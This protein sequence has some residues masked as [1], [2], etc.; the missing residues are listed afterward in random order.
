MQAIIVR[1]RCW[2][3]GKEFNA[4]PDAECVN[5]PECNAGNMIP[6]YADFRKEG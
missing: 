4:H 5:C 1:V 6:V 2:S 3:C